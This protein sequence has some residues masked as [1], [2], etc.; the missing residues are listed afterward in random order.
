MQNVALLPLLHLLPLLNR[1][2]DGLGQV[3]VAHGGWVPLPLPLPQVRGLPT[4]SPGWH[5]W[6]VGGGDLMPLDV[7]FPDVAHFGGQV[8]RVEAHGRH[9]PVG[10]ALTGSGRGNAGV[11]QAVIRQ[12]AVAIGER[13]GGEDTLV[14]G[15]GHRRWLQGRQV[16]LLRPAVTLLQAERA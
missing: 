5:H 9:S 4:Y 2:H 10:H 11:E 12:T 14:R 15:G 7:R 3:I 16:A 1:C 8:G 13:V 6:A